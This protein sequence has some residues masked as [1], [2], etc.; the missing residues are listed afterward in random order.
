MNVFGVPVAKLP[1][2]PVVLSSQRCFEDVIWPG[3]RRPNRIAHRLA[4]GVVVNC[5]ALE[6]HLLRDYAVPAG[7]I[8][9]C[10]NGLDTSVF[11]PD[12][13]PRPGPD[14]LRD[15]SLVIGSV[16]VLRPEKDLATLLR[17]FS[18][19][20][21]LRPGTV[22]VIVG[23]GPVREAL[24]TQAKELGMEA[25]C[26]FY[27]ATED[28]ASWLHAIDVFVLPSRSEAFSN[29]LM[30]AMAC[31]CC[32]IASEVGGNPELVRHGETGLLFEPGNASDLARQLQ[33]PVLD[34]P[35]RNRLAN[36]GAAWVAT[37]LSREAA[38]RRME[39]IYLHY[40]EKP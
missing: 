39:E 23:S 16:C 11:G 5:Q 40:L 28:V 17:A 38:A 7:K 19:V 20:R 30:E 31:G 4:D 25:D 34:G 6:R 22:L 35:M 21:G 26:L 14:R 36:A 12:S 8:R 37:N 13:T 32:A 9:I 24:A 18:I 2:G 10:R 33:L 29:S 3:H 1:G 27:P 15:A